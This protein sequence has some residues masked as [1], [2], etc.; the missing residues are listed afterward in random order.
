MSEHSSGKIK[1]PVV[2]SALQG[3]DYVRQR[4]L[5]AD[6]IFGY[7]SS[8]KSNWPSRGQERVYAR[9]ATLYSLEIIN[10]VFVFYRY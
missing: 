7:F 2:L 4:S 8:R 6:L 10:V 5:S 9:Q 1:Q 3:K